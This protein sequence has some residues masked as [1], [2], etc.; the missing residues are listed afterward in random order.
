MIVITN[1]VAM[2]LRLIVVSVLLFSFCSAPALAIPI[3]DPT[4]PVWAEESGDYWG[5]EYES[6]K[7]MKEK[8]INDAKRKAIDKVVGVY[9][10][11]YT[12]VSNAQLADDLVRASVRGRIEKVEYADARVDKENNLH[13]I[14]TVKVLVKPVFPERGERIQVKLGL[15][16]SALKEGDEI[17][18][19]YQVNKDSYVYIY[20][21]AAD[22]SVTLLFPNKIYPDNK[23]LADA[24]Q[25]YPP[26][27]GPIRLT[28]ECLPNSKE[29]LMM[30][31]VKIIA[32]RKKEIVLEDFKQGFLVYD[33]SSTGLVSELERRLRQL[34]WADWGEVTATYSVE[35]TKD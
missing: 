13:F 9:I 2:L 35:R 1:G 27:E 32:T 14:A 16:K 15:T 8:A 31:K 21:I 18:I 10:D 12:L 6:A 17:R 26:D 34:E 25:Y 3:P 23:V 19:S 22:N 33:S 24:G 30:E 5:S 11:S 29:K 4:A 20:S 7:E 28:A